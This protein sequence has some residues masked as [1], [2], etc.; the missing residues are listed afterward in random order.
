MVGLGISPGLL[1]M[2]VK[3]KL[4]EVSPVPGVAPLKLTVCGPEFSRIGAGLLIG[5]SVGAWLIPVT[6]TVKDWV[7]VSMAPLA[8]PPLSITVTVIVATPLALGTGV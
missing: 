2:A 3:V 5:P 4:W 8:V 1:L 6:V 7:T